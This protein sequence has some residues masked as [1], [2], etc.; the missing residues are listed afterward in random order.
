MVEKG[1]VNAAGVQPIAIQ[2]GDGRSTDTRHNSS[3]YY[4]KSEQ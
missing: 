4:L 2:C 3:A 1:L